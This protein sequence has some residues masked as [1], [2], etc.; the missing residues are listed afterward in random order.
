VVL[1]FHLKYSLASWRL[2]RVFASP[3]PKKKGKKGHAYILIHVVGTTLFT[4]ATGSPQNPALVLIGGIHPG[5][6]VVH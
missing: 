4:P 5:I 3:P 1:L 6:V 2:L